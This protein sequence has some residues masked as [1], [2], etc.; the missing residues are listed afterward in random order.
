VRR[1]DGRHATQTNGEQRRH[2]LV[3][4]SARAVFG[5]NGGRAKPVLLSSGT[6]SGAAKTARAADAALALKA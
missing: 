1:R 6:A 2:V 3:Q 4:T 5:V